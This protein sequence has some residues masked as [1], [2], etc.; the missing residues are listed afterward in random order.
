M[1][2]LAIHSNLRLQVSVSHPLHGSRLI[3]YKAM[4]ISDNPNL[5]QIIRNVRQNKKGYDVELVPKVEENPGSEDEESS[6]ILVHKSILLKYQ[7]FHD[8]EYRL[9]TGRLST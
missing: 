3:L 6:T 5:P 8:S 7:F 4:Q 1:I 9:F 2:P